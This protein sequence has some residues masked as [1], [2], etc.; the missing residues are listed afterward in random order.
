MTLCKAVDVQNILSSSIDWIHLTLSKLGRNATVI[1]L[2]ANSKAGARVVGHIQ[3][4]VVALHVGVCG[5]WEQG[6][7]A[8]QC[9]C[10]NR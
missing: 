4:S 6:K 2:P 10:R 8:R 5:G 1:S 3:Q 7:E 9:L